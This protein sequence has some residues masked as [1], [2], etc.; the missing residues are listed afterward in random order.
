M[1]LDRRNVL[2]GSAAALGASFVSPTSS[3]AATYSFRWGYSFP[4]SHPVHVRAVEAAERIKQE[5][6][7]QLEVQPFPGGQLG[8]EA[9][10][11]SQVRSGGLELFCTSGSVIGSIIAQAAVPGVGF[12]FQDYETVWRA[13][14][15]EL[16]KHVRRLT[17]A[18][19]LHLFERIF[20]NGFRQ[21]TSGTQPIMHVK[22][23]QGFKIR[24][25]QIQ[26]YASLFQ[27]LGGAPV[28]LTF[29]ELYTALQ[30]KL[31]DGQENPLSL[32]QTGRLYEV[33]KSV[34]LTDHVWEGIW[35][36]AND[37]AWQA[38]PPQIKAIA[39]SAF[40][41]AAVAQREDIRKINDSVQS[42]LSLKGISFHK[43]DIQSFKE[44]LSQ[45]GFYNEWRQTLGSDAWLV[46][47]KYVG[48]LA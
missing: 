28:A 38:L 5:T 44:K 41:D 36:V 46:L 11:L 30:T 9:Q 15:G 27:K 34:S 39:T 7:G 43:P 37:P 21:I 25:P 29:S 12:A 1:S 48:K 16:G 45:S 20:D 3:R 22:D 40:N 33:Q 4:A 31:V 47:E 6:N 8:S 32:F 17:S 2:K 18:S 10:M 42:E 13:M 19:K 26:L 35:I 23:L 24:V 14:D